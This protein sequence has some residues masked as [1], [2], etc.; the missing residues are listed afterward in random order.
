MRLEHIKF[1]RQYDELLNDI[2]P[3]IVS[4]TAA[5]QDLSNSV[6]FA[7]YILLLSKK[8]KF[9]NL[10]KKKTGKTWNFKQFYM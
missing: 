6:K 5:C 1:M 4:V 3:E 9:D 2:K 8:L 10:G 7:S